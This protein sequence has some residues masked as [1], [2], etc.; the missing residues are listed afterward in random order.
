MTAA[1]IKKDD[2]PVD[3]SLEDQLKICTFS[4][5]YKRVNYL[6]QL[7][8][9][10]ADDIEKLDDAATEVMISAEDEVKY[11]FGESFVAVS[12]DTITELLEKEK[13]TLEEEKAQV[14]KEL[15]SRQEE[16]ASLKAV[17]YAKFGNQIYL[18]DQ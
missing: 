7:S 15:A 1:Q 2:V 6:K 5:F 4:R 13:E 18:D 8:Q 9:L 14:E 17:L 10:L 11:V 12:N 3:V 16:L